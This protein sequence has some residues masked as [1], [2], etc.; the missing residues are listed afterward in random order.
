MLENKCLVYKPQ[1]KDRATAY[2]ISWAIYDSITPL[3]SLP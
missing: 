2:E 3:E 1:A